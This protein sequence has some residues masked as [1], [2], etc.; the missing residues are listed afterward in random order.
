[1]LSINVLLQPHVFDSFFIQKLKVRVI[2]ECMLYSNKYGS[3]ISSS[4]VKTSYNYSDEYLDTILV[5]QLVV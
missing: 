4:D 1:M 5:Q 3:L 2:Y